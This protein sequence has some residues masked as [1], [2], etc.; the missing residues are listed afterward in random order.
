MVSAGQVQHLKMHFEHSQ[1]WSSEDS[2]AEG[3]PDAFWEKQHKQR[4]LEQDEGWR[5]SF[6]LRSKKPT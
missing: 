2:E 1:C 4:A 5:S 3:Q 6:S